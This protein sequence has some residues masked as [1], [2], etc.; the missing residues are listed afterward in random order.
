VKRSVSTPSRIGFLSAWAGAIVVASFG[1]SGASAAEFEARTSVGVLST[2]NLLRTPI[3]QSSQIATLDGTFRVERSSP[4]LRILA[5]GGVL[6]RNYD[7][8]GI[9]DDLLPSLRA[10]TEWAMVK[11]VLGWVADANLGQLARNS[12][13]GLVPAD[14]EAFRVLT[15]GPDLRL[16]LGSD[17]ALYGAARYS[18]ID[19]EVSPF[20]GSKAGIEAGIERS[21]GANSRW[22]VLASHSETDFSDSPGDFTLD[23][24]VFSFAAETRRT[25]VS[26]NLGVQRLDDSIN[27]QDGWLGRLSI[28]RRVGNRSTVSLDAVSR[29]ASVAELL[30]RRQ[31]LEPDVYTTVNGIAASGPVREDGVTLTWDTAARRSTLLAAISYFNDGFISDPG[32]TNRSGQSIF[33]ASSLDLTPQITWELDFTGLREAPETGAS[34]YT[35]FVTTTLVWKFSRSLSVSG[36]GEYYQETRRDVPRIAEARWFARLNW[37]YFGLQPKATVAPRLPKSFRRFN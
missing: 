29:F 4:S 11:D 13:G 12:T 37:S 27:P 28:R 17:Y 18:L 6:Y 10:A 2:D 25:D 7:L 5:D 21:L 20:D 15:T 30:E 3:G 26:L 14:L 23:S 19:Y 9:E 32:V 35:R 1:L 36:G 34:L 24:I 31:D 8:E 33:L 16:S 22:R